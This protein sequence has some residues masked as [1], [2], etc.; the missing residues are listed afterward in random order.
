M[1]VIERA[2]PGKHA[3]SSGLPDPLLDRD[4]WVVTRDK[5]PIRPQSGWND[6]ANQLSARTAIFQSRSLGG[7]PGFI[8]DAS[9]PFLLID[10]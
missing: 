1:M 10:L 8:L 6:P 5:K 9:D 3:V 4:Q 2:Q 7:Q